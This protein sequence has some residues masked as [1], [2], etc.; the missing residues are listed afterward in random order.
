MTCGSKG[1]PRA[2][3][4]TNLTGKPLWSWWWR[5]RCGTVAAPSPNS[6]SSL[7]TTDI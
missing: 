4:Q 6:Y 3:S 2:I 1:V 7:G 5:K